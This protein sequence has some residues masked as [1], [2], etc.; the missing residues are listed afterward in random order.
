MEVLEKEYQHLCQLLG[1]SNVLIQGSGGNISVK[2]GDQ[3]LIKASGTRLRDNHTA[4]CSITG[5]REWMMLGPEGQETKRKELYPFDPFLS[6]VTRNMTIARPS[7]EVFFHLLP[8][9]WVIH[10]HPT[11]LLR[12]L[13]S[14]DWTQLTL[15]G[16][17][18]AHIPYTTPGEELGQRII[19]TYSPEN[20]Q[21][22]WFLQ[23]HGVILCA[24]TVEE[25]LHMLDSLTEA[26]S[27]ALTPIRYQDLWALQTEAQTLAAREM[28]LSVC[29]HIRDLHDRY[30][31]PITPDIQLFLRNTPLAIE[32]PSIH[33][34][35]ALHTHWEK[36]HTLPA[37]L[38]LPSCVC[39]LGTSTD[40]CLFT[41]EILESYLE[42]V[43][44]QKELLTFDE[45]AIHALQTSK[46]EQYRLS[47]N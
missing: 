14:T 13:C 2:E 10:L 12:R 21:T 24:K 44:H 47:Q 34:V 38:K 11:W 16:H 36:T 42:I 23:N 25:G 1:S 43:K 29:S 18:C 4:L 7:M 8:F 39:I 22:V 35:E 33:P 46:A 30:F 9:Q 19:D 3:L 6:Y 15:A 40:M 37:V 20:P 28:V 45:A 27:G 5:L 32:E 17:T 31:L 26:Y 41:E